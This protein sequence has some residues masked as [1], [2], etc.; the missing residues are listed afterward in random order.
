[1]RKVIESTASLSV[2]TLALKNALKK[3][4]VRGRWG[5]VQLKNCI[6][7][8]GMSEHADV[9]FQDSQTDEEGKL[10]IPDMTVRMPGGR[11]VVVDS[12]TPIDAFLASLEATTEE[13][14]AAEMTRHGRHVRDHVKKLSQRAYYEGLKESP[15]FTIM[16]LPNE[17]FLY[18]ALESEPDLM[19]EAL[20]RK[21]L[22]TTPP[23]LI[24]LLKVIRYGWNEEKLAENA[25]KISTVGKELH[26]RLVEFVDGYLT[27]G[28]SLEKAKLE[29]DKGFNRLERRLISKAREME[30]LGAKSTKSLPDGVGES[31]LSDSTTPLK[32]EAPSLE[33]SDANPS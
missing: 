1:L 27:V 14:R 19:E 15:D 13:Q 33:D 10:H 30:A 31:E 6:E 22:I 3:P 7:L 16:F 28:K 9:T 21:V 11:I 12:K 4:H 17:S 18:A 8:A 24:G 5:E 32:L 29:Y 25:A 26:K 23:T 20:Q 2:E